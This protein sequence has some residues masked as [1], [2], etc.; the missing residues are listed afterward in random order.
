MSKTLICRDCD[1]EKP[2]TKE[3]FHFR[4]DANK[5]S[6][7][8]RICGAKASK[9]RHDNRTPDQIVKDRARYMNTPVPERLHKEAFRRARRKG[10]EFSI[11]PNDITAPEYCPVFPSMKLDSHDLHHCPTLDRLNNS[12]GY[13]PGNVRVISHRANSIKGF[14][15]AEELYRVA[16]YAAGKI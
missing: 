6:R 11:T 7:Q 5:F 4:S 16:E 14:A 15:T 3:F 10:L 8:C 1:V 9:K 12:K 2:M 13:I